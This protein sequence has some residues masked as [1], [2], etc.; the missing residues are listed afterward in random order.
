[1]RAPRLL[2]EYP[3]KNLH[4]TDEMIAFAVTRERA[5]ISGADIADLMNQEFPDQVRPFTKNM[6]VGKLGRLRRAALRRARSTAK[7][8]EPRV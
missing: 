6:L 7:M 8:V 5:R 1:M 3:G 2:G 4:W